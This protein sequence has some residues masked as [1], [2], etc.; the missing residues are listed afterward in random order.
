MVLWWGFQYAL[1]CCQSDVH[2]RVWVSEAGA[3]ADQL[4]SQLSVPKVLSN[5]ESGQP[6]TAQPVKLT[7]QCPL[8]C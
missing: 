7:T 1:T 4:V 6:L 2:Y 5:C 8:K 3:G